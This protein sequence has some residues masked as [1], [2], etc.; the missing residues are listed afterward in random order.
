MACATILRRPWN[1]APR[2]T[3]TAA[4]CSDSDSLGPLFC[5]SDRRDGV[6]CRPGVEESLRNFGF[7]DESLF[8]LGFQVECGRVK[9]GGEPPFVA[10]G[11]PHSK[12]LRRGPRRDLA[13]FLI[14]NDALAQIL[15]GGLEHCTAQVFA[16]YVKTWE[17]LEDAQ[18][19]EEGLVDFRHARR[20][21][22]INKC[23]PPAIGV[24][25]FNEVVLGLRLHA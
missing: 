19:R 9:S 11:K 7:Q 25:K 18:E 1:W 2:F 13:D 23:R 15:P 16:G 14:L 21:W 20:R 4:G 24:H 8:H 12:T 10:Q 6:F 22:R 5:H 3:K 17:R